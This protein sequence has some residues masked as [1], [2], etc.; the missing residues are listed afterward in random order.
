MQTK[1]N[2]T[3]GGEFKI[4]DNS[5]DYV[6][7]FNI[8]EKGNAYTGKYYD[9]NSILLSNTIS[10]YSSDYHKSLNFKDRYVYDTI[11]LPYSLEEILIQP[12]ELVNFNVL[13]KKLEYIH[14]N[15]SYVYSKLFTGSTTVPVDENPNTLC[16]LSGYTEFNWNSKNFSKALGYNSLELIPKL[17]QYSEFDKIHKIV[18]IPF[19]DNS[20]VS[21]FAISNTHLI[22]LSSIIS[23]ND[24]LSNPQFVLYTN[25][26]DNY[27]EETCKNLQDITYDGRYLYVS[28]SEINGGG[29]VF[30]YDVTGFYTND[31]IFVGKRFLVEPIGGTGGIDSKNK[32]N[33]CTIL[34][35]NQNQIWVYDSG[36]GAI[37]IFD[38]DLIW[39]KTIRIANTKATTYTILDIRHRIM[40]NHI[41]VLFKKEYK[42][43]I[44]D[45]NSYIKYGLFE[46]NEKYLLEN[47]FIFDDY[48]FSDTD[49]E[50]KRMAISQ[51]D[52]N[53]FYVMTNSNVFKKFFTKPEKTFAVF[54]REKYYPS[55]SF[56]WDIVG[57]SWDTEDAIETW[58][59]SA[60]ISVS[61]S[62]NDIY[63]VNSN[64][65]KDDLYFAGPSYIT[66][67]KE[68]TEYFSLLQNNNLPYYNFNKIKFKNFEYN[69]SLTLN[70]EIYKLFSNII[71]FKNNLKGRFFAEYNK[72]SDIVYNDYI[73]LTD[74][75]INTLDIDLDYNCFVNDNELVQPNVINRIFSKIYELQKNLMLLSQARL[76]NIK[77]WVDIKGGSGDGYPIT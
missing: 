15:L 57:R 51:Q 4:S 56:I 60:D 33:K 41:Y 31:E 26:I 12:N 11:N 59:Y 65:N 24:E 20:G 38:S 14:Y 30:K 62:T 3:S 18:V 58:G 25:V 1:F 66:H 45:K 47:T 2:Y 8:D 17:K 9:S 64:Q 67:F 50:F 52:S 70:K 37:K 34:G 39:K 74:E 13:N 40:N 35:S 61:I 32:F 10:V 29:Q 42:D 16:S 73:Y 48:L 54:N 68:R 75:E 7:Y 6:G 55:D 69:Q 77:T 21:I 63:I 43:P 22:G 53:V 49:K 23:N 44:D 28:D 46:Y 5:Q 27:S 19:K 71:Q 76:K 72:Y 36:N